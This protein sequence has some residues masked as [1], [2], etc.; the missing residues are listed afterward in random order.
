SFLEHRIKQGNSLLGTTPALMAQGIPDDAFNPIEGDDKAVV[1]KYKK[2][3]REERRQREAGVYQQPLFAAPPA[4]YA[5]LSA[6]IA[7]LDAL[8]DDTLDGI[9]EKEARYRKLA[10]DEEYQKARGL[11]DAW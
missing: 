5:R 8:D 1:S 11:A 7:A 9:R 3:N 4:D 6:G 10:E 2:Q